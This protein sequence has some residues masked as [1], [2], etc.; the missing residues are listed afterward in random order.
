MPWYRKLHWQ[1]IIG[2]ILGAVYG[3]VA[4]ANG[5]GG[6]TSDWIAPWGAIFMNSLR[7]IA[8][9]LVLGSLVTGVAS[10]SDLR[11]LSRI[12]GKTIGIYVTTTA[13]ASGH[14][15]VAGQHAEAGRAD[16]RGDTGDAAGG[17]CHRCGAAG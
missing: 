16:P 1:I 2:L 11:R 17:L 5:W 12:G 4:A 6:F 15:P 3:V 8:V 9:P 13:I 7:L 14:R 10:L